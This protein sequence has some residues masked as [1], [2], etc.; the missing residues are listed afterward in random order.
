[1]LKNNR[2][3]LWINLI[4]SK[5]GINFENIEQYGTMS[6]KA[7]KNGKRK[8][9]LQILINKFETLNLEDFLTWYGCLDLIKLDAK[10]H[11]TL[12]S[13]EVDNLY[14]LSGIEKAQLV[15]SEYEFKL[16]KKYINL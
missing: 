8:A 16:F 11:N 15:F 2:V 1:M 9:Y 4:N 7:F 5:Y 3:N 13:K 14:G 6:H 12:I 10:L